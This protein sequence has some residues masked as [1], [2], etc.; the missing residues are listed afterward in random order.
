[1]KRDNLKS[2]A[3]QARHPIEAAKSTAKAAAKAAAKKEAKKILL[4]IAPYVGGLILI[5]HKKPLLNL[6]I[7]NHYKN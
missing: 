3:Y 6:E 7:Q 5:H 1:M 2:K 4:A